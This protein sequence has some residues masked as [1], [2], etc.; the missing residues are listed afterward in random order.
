MSF[1]FRIRT[2]EYR[3]LPVIARA[4]KPSRPDK[5]RKLGYKAKDGYVI[6]RVR[7]RRGGRKRPVP[8]GIVSGKPSSVGIN[9]LKPTRN[10]RSKA[11]ERVGRAIGGLRVLNSYW[12]AQDG[13][14]KYYEVIMCDP[15]HNGIRNDP[16]INWIAK[17]HQ[18]HR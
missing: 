10:L 14:Y 12:I 5:A 11:E 9:Q 16:R 15:A 8:K 13:T 2:W 4:N 18:K 17:P 6:Y 3:Q 7:V 1:I